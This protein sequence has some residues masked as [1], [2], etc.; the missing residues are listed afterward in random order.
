M[1]AF[2][3]RKDGGALGYDTEARAD[4]ER[5]HS[6]AEKI[7]PLSDAVFF[8]TAQTQFATF[9]Q[10]VTTEKIV[11]ATEKIHSVTDPIVSATE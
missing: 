8:A 9:I 11:F 7:G 5:I 2:S 3:T 4:P 6:G 1:M 10:A